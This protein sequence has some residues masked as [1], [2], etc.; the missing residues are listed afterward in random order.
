MLPLNSWTLSDSLASPL[1]RL[2]NAARDPARHV[3]AVGHG[4]GARQSAGPPSEPVVFTRECLEQTSAH[5]ASL[6]IRPRWVRPSVNH[7]LV[8]GFFVLDR[9]SLLFFRSTDSAFARCV[10]QTLLSGAGTDEAVTLSCWAGDVSPRLG[11]TVRTNASLLQRHQ[12]S[13]NSPDL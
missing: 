6:R 1:V 9:F 8:L 11:L 4:V 5:K 13:L 10:S 7:Q 3:T 12:Q 2:R